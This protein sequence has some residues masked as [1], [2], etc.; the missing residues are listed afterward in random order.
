MTDFPLA[1][2]PIVAHAAINERVALRG[3]WRLVSLLFHGGREYQIIS[4]NNDHYYAIDAKGRRIKRE[5][6][7]RDD[8]HRVIS[9]P[10]HSYFAINKCWMRIA[11]GDYHE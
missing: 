10:F 3:P 2:H 1:L 7:L 11:N 4:Y 6:Y 8:Q 5:Y 9:P